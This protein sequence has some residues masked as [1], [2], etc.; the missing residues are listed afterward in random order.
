MKLIYNGNCKTRF[1]YSL[2]EVHLSAKYAAVRFYLDR[3]VSD[4]VEFCT[5]HAYKH[6]HT[7]THTHTRTYIRTH[8]R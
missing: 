1:D 6:T 5:S 2:R 7:H 4:N 8:T 3:F